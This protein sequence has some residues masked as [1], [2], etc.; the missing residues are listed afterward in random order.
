[1]VLRE[2][3][4]AIIRLGEF[5]N[6]FFKMMEAGISKVKAAVAFPKRKLLP[7]TDLESK[8]KPGKIGAMKL[9]YAF[10]VWLA[11]GAV[12]GAGIYLATVKG[13][14]WL[15]IVGFAGFVFAVGK[16]GCAHH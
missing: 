3:A 15:L 12:L 5:L 4:Q 8:V 2:A 10:G 6:M 13:S 14:P 9:I 11:M 16:I 7:E 1:M